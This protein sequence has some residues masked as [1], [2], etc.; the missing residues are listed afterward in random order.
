MVAANAYEGGDQHCAYVRD[1]V[2]GKPCAHK[3]VAHEV[4]SLERIAQA[5]ADAEERGA[6]SQQHEATKETHA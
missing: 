4:E 1:F 6:A 3:S 2:D 5:I